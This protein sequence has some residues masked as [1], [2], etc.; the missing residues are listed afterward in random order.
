MPEGFNVNP[1]MVSQLARR[2]KMGEGEVPMDWAFGRGGGLGFAR[3][4]R[5]T[6][7]T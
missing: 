3:A 7:A 6:R 2:A 1:K 5:H 4:R